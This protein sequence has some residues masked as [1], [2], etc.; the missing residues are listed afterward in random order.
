MFEFFLKKIW[1]LKDYFMSCAD[2]FL[3]LNKRSIMFCCSTFNDVKTDHS[4]WLEI[5]K[6]SKQ[7]SRSQGDVESRISLNG[8][9]HCIHR[10]GATGKKINFLFDILFSVLLLRNLW[11]QSRWE[12]KCND[13]STKRKSDKGPRESSKKACHRR[14]VSHFIEYLESLEF[15]NGRGL[16]AP[17]SSMLLVQEFPE[18]HGFT[19][20]CCLFFS[21]C[22]MTSTIP[23]VPYSSNSLWFYNHHPL[24]TLYS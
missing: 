6:Q 9:N 19:F 12:K 14:I 23:K 10:C 1:K 2:Y 11:T 17:H 7:Q 15:S 16:V 8:M 24:P 22:R 13:S 3:L 18:G 4:T 5:A 21:H 20:L